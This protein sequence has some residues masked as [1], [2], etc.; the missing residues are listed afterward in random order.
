MRE[1]KVMVVSDWKLCWALLGYTRTEVM[2]QGTGGIAGKLAGL[3]GR[4]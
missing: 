4:E 3:E 2:E 1:A